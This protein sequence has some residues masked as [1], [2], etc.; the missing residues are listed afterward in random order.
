MGR[1]RYWFHPKTH[2][3]FRKSKSIKEN[4][5]TLKR[6]YGTTPSGLLHAAR[7][8]IALANVTRDKVTKIKARKVAEYFL[9]AYHRKKLG[10]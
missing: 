9:E 8:M 6:R 10:L 7:A 3:G 5:R 4:I 2:S 1:T